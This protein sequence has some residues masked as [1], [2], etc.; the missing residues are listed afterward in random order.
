MKNDQITVLYGDDSC[1][2]FDAVSSIRFENSEGNGII[3]CSLDN[4]K[5][6][7]TVYLRCFDEPPK[8]PKEDPVQ[9]RL[10]ALEKFQKYIERQMQA[11]LKDL[12]G[13][14]QPGDTISMDSRANQIERVLSEYP[15]M[16]LYKRQTAYRAE[17]F[18]SNSKLIAEVS[19]LQEKVKAL[20][21]Q[22]R[23]ISPDAGKYICIDLGYPFKK[24]YVEKPK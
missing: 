10:E 6:A 12:N 24:I 9:Q 3:T 1:A 4:L 14:M 17:F 18:E 13:G 2:T 5:R 20:E 16:T 23:E 7:I 15:L 21:D 8:K 19:A 22:H 11:C